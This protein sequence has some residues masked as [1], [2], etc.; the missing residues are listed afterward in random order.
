MCEEIILSNGCGEDESRMTKSRPFVEEIFCELTER[1]LNTQN[2][3]CNKLKAEIE[4]SLKRRELPVG[5]SLYT[6]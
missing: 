6:H 3:L 1:S 5:E 4:Y 2:P